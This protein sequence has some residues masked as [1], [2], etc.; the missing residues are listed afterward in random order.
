MFKFTKKIEVK[1]NKSENDIKVP[2]D[3]SKLD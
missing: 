2:F 1:P 3:L